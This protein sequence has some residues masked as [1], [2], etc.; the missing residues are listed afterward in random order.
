[1]A[2]SRTLYFPS[3]GSPSVSPA[4]DSA[5]FDTTSADRIAAVWDAPS[6]TAFSTKTVTAPSLPYPNAHPGAGTGYDF[7]PAILVRQYVTPALYENWASSTAYGVGRVVIDGSGHAQQVTTAGTSGGS[8]PT[9]NTSGGETTDGTVVWQDCG[10]AAYTYHTFYGIVG[11]VSA[12]LTGGGTGSRVLQ[13]SIIKIFDASNTLRATLRKGGTSSGGYIDAGWS[14][15]GFAAS[16]ASH[17]LA[18]PNAQTT[19]VLT[20]AA[21]DYL[22]I[23]LGYCPCIFNS[24]PA[25]SAAS[26]SF[27]FGDSAAS[28]LLWYGDTAQKNPWARFDV[29]QT[30]SGTAP[31]PPAATGAWLITVESGAAVDRTQYLDFTEGQQNEFQLMLRQRGRAQ[32]PMKVRAGD[33]YTP[34]TGTPVYLYEVTPTASTLVFSGTMDDVSLVYHGKAGDRTY[35]VTAVSLEQCFDVVQ[36]PPQ[37]FASGTSA[38]TIITSLYN[39]YLTGALV[40]LGALSAGATIGGP[41]V[42]KEWTSFAKILDDLATTSQ[43][44]WGVDPQTQAL[45]FRAPSTTAAPFSLANAQMRWESIRWR[46]KRHDYRNRQLLTISPD[47]FAPS[48]DLLQGNGSAQT[49]TLQRAPSEVKAAWITKNTQNSATITVS[50]QPSNGDTLTISYPTSGSTYNWHA[51]SPYTTGQIIIDPAGHIQKCT[52]GGTSG[53][54]QPS[55]SDTTTGGG[56]TADGSVVWTDQGQSGG[57]SFNDTVYTFVTSLDNTQFGQVLIGSTTTKT[58]QNLADAINS[59]QSVAGK[60]FSLPTWENPLLNASRSGTVVTVKNKSA[61]QGYIAALAKSSAGL[62]LSA[63]L[64]SGGSTSLGTIT[65]EVAQE[66]SSNTA[67]L[68][69]TPGSTTVKL[70]SVPNNGVSLPLSS[71][72]YL[73]VQY[74]R[75]GGDTI[76]C[77]NSTEVSTRAGVEGGLGKYQA[78]T[79]DTTILNAQIGL[80]RCQQ[81]LSAYGTIPVEFSFTT[82]KPGLTPGQYLTISLSDSPSGIASLVNGNYII[83]EV[84]ARLV[85]TKP[86]M[87]QNTVPGGGHYEYTVTVFNVGVVSSYLDFWQG[88]AGAGSSAESGGGGGGLS[89]GLAGSSA[90]TLVVQSD[91]TLIGVEGTI[92]FSSALSAQALYFNLSDN[93]S[94]GRVDIGAYYAITTPNLVL[95]TKDGSAGVPLWRSLVGADFGLQTGNRVLAGPTSGTATPTFRALVAADFANQSANTVLAGPSSGSAAAPSF[96]A[97]VSAD[98]P[99]IDLTTSGAGGVT[100]TLPIGK[101]GTSATSASV[102]FSNLYTGSQLPIANGGTGA[103][104][105]AAGFAALYAGSQLPVANGGTGAGTTSAARTNLGLGTAAIRNDAYFLQSAN[106]L[107][108]ITNAFSARASLGLGTAA[109]YAATDFLLASNGMA[110]AA[111]RV[112]TNVDF[113]SPGFDYVTIYVTNGQI[114]NIV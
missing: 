58:A 41:Y 38:S 97:L 23:E 56:T 110:S 109:T 43:Y 24:L 60:T 64:T 12:S 74:N 4:F 79:S 102:A 26:A 16:L 44:V 106:N 114:T 96:R 82:L 36:I 50:S 85:R 68:Y 100:G 107:S 112:V 98:I 13:C 17:P 57:G 101:G 33:S 66:G 21:G 108:D 25:I 11:R 20:P 113:V 52:T 51:S 80:Q 47:A 54:S 5:W 22:V 77:E 103:S 104:T 27:E 99:T 40:S 81:E 69:W 86:Y 89:I 42:I 30:S 62:N 2:G 73:Q 31:T 93:P 1:M 71:S 46:A 55:W 14:T 67:N 19:P 61:G 10:T 70:A 78:K 105:A 29:A 53:G 59:T 45:Y 92:N 91:G 84:Q 39:T 3:S 75:L 8:A 88:L 28:D 32:I 76:A 65:L 83:Q 87:D 37:S 35:A 34:A 63:S 94:N 111:Q 18:S 72:W 90:G 49:F 48:A 15:S 7:Q 9:W 6:S 95:C